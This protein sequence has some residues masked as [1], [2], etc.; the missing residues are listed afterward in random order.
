MWIVGRPFGAIVYMRKQRRV[1]PHG[2]YA[3]DKAAQENEK[4]IKPRRDEGE[5]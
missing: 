4:D 3:R 1:K 5:E 2:V